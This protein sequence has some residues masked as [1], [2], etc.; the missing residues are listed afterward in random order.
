MARLIG[1]MCLEAIIER[2]LNQRL[3]ISDKQDVLGLVR[4]QKQIRER[5]GRA[6]LSGASCHNKQRS[7]PGFRK[8]LSDAPDGFVLVSA[9]NDFGADRLGFERLPILPNKVQTTEVIC[10]EWASHESGIGIADI[11]EIPVE[12][13][14][15]ESE[16]LEA[17]TP[18]DL[19]QVMPQLL[20]ALARTAAGALRLDHSDHFSG[21]SVETVIGDAVPRRGIVAIHRNLKSNLGSVAKP[22]PSLLEGRVDQD[23]ARRGFIE[24][25]GVGRQG[26]A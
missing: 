14:R 22:P 17:L 6:R 23:I 9:V 7:T 19:R 3:A 16:R 26:H 10:L 18:R 2:L 1:E 12:A 25:G 8:S 5:H 21:G 20:F 24:R 4:S 13:V 11:P 15:H